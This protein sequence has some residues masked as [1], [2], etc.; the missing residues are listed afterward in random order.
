LS[1]TQKSETKI[2]KKKFKFEEIEITTKKSRTIERNRGREILLK[3]T[4]VVRMKASRT[5]IPAPLL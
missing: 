3:H 1:A 5:S 2:Q 4:A